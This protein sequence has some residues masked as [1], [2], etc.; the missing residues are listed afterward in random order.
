MDGWTDRPRLGIVAERE[1]ERAH[2]TVSN[3][4]IYFFL[5]GREGLGIKCRSPGEEV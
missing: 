2:W 1:R 4:L 5:K 3:S